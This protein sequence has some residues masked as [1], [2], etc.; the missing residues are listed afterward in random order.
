MAKGRIV[1][2]AALVLGL[3]CGAS[4]IPV[5]TE[6][7]LHRAPIGSTVES[8]NRGRELYLR[9]CSGCHRLHAPSERGPGEWPEVV[10]AMEAKIPLDATEKKLIID[11]LV[12]AASAGR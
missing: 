9:K 11:Y 1:W 3:A 10:K 8:L 12:T 6:A 5:V 4:V 7:D 2:A